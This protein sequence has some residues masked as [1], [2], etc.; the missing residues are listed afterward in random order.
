MNAESKTS[1]LAK[2]EARAVLSDNG[3]C[4]LWT[5]KPKKNQNAS[6]GVL[7][8]TIR[9]TEYKQFYVHPLAYMAHHDIFD[10]DPKLECSHLC[11]NSLCV[12]PVHICLETHDVNNNRQACKTNGVCS[13]HGRLPDCRLDLVLPP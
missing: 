13:G 2:L 11:H 12:N 7:K 4:R 8:L 9:P 1:V 5:G 10:L 3:E 6:Y